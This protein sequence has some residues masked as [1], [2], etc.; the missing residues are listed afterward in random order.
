VNT[1]ELDDPVEA[2]TGAHPYLTSH[3]ERAKA[4]ANMYVSS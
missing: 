3:P 2:A 1:S 4:F